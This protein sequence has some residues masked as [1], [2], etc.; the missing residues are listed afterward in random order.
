MGFARIR[1]YG[2]K[3]ETQFSSGLD[4]AVANGW[5][6]WQMQQIWLA[7]IGGLILGWLIEWIVDW[8]FWR[9]NI[10]TLRQENQV[11]RRQLEE[12]QA[13]LDAIQAPAAAPAPAAGQPNMPAVATPPADPRSQ[14]K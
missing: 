7:L 13:Q 9:R 5:E 1:I 14:G 11:L 8:L 2:R 12:A 6:T 3:E 10:A 4:N